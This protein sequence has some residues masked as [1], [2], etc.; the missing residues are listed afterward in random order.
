MITKIDK[1]RSSL[2][3]AASFTFKTI[4]PT[5]RFKSFNS[6]NILIKYQGKEVGN[7]EPEAPFRIRLM[8]MKT[9]KIT[10][11]NPNC[12]WKWITLKKEFTS[13]DESKEF[14]NKNAEAIIKTYTLHQVD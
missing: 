13:L 8:V 9:D 5:G 3:E 10:D 1:F 14:L 12:A 2:N 4:K 11:N 7:I 6:D